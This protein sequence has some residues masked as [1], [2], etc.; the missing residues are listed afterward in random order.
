MI[1]YE[2]ELTVMVSAALTMLL[3]CFPQFCRHMTER[4]PILRAAIVA[5]LIYI[6]ANAIVSCAFPKE[7][8]LW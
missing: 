6:T 7:L 8:T 5:I 4:A 1:L 2:R 3:C